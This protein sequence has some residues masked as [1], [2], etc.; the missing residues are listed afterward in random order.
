MRGCSVLS[1][2]A[3]ARVWTG[4]GPESVSEAEGPA[5]GLCAQSSYEGQHPPAKDLSRYRS[6]NK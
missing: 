3:G 4:L 5:G 6:A 2:E 1:R